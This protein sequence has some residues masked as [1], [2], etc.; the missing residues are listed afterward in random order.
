MIRYLTQVRSSL[1]EWT[2]WVLPILP[3]GVLAALYLHSA[4]ERRREN[5]DDKLLPLPADLGR[6]AVVAISRDEFTEK[7]PIVEDLRT[8]LRIYALG[9]GSAVTVALVC[10]LHIGVWSWAHGMFDPMLRFFS[11][12]PPLALLPLVM[13]FLG[14]GDLAKV[15]LIFISVV[16]PL[17]RGLVLRVQAVNER[18]IWNAMTLGASTPELVW[19]VFRRLTEPGFLDDVRLL[20]GT[21]WVYLIAAELIASN[22]GLGYR[23]SVA[24]RNLNVAQI[25]LYIAVICLLAFIMDRAIFHFN[26][27]RNR[28]AFA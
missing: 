14:I 1:P 19:I 9:F 23:I 16:I 2:K 24:G 6:A 25:F 8:S 27:W 26:R 22:A 20:I 13:L 5:P 15:F 17:T 7:I 21:A 12:L 28:W 11:Y 18:E 10:G 3:L 4:G